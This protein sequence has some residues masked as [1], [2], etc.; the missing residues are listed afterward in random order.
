MNRLLFYF[1]LL[2]LTSCSSKQEKITI[3]SNVGLFDGYSYKSNVNLAFDGE[4]IIEI[5]EQT[6]KYK[7]ANEIDGR[8]KTIIPPLLNAHV[9]VWRKNDLKE[10]LNAGVFALLDMHNTDSSSVELRG[11]RN[12]QDCAYYYSSGPGA[13]VPAGH[14][15]EYGVYVPTINH[16]VSPQQFIKDRINNGSDYIKIFREPCMPTLN[17]TQIKEVITTT[18]TNNKL[19]VAHVSLAKDA[20]VIGEQH[21]DGFA[22]LWF[23]T[24]ATETQWDSITRYKAFIIPTLYVTTGLVQSWKGKEFIDEWLVEENILKEA[25]KAYEK[26]MTILAGTDA[27]NL[28]FNYGTD[29]YQELKLLSKAG[30]PNIDVMKAATTNVS[31]CF[32]LKEFGPLEKGKPSSFILINGNP[33]HNIN[34]IEKIEG[35]WKLG[36]RIK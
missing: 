35:I 34:D 9:H 33:L 1:A 25:K 22:H 29:L 4:K 21:I 28:N 16:S 10:A 6:L 30:I 20:A 32:K 12:N 31:T 3:I 13:T 23:D 11:Y 14:G 27:P 36:R 26:G 8:G 5:S 7:N 19:A 18:H 24:T 17:Y 2:I 15:T